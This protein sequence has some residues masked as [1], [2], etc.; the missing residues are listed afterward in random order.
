M[1][2]ADA[3]DGALPP[4]PQEGVP[5]LITKPLTTEEDKSFALKLVADSI[6]QQRNI[7]A[8]AIIFHPVIVA[9]YIGLMTIISQY[10][11]KDKGNIGVV[12]TTGAGVTMACLVAIRSATAGYLVVAEEMTWKWSQN[13]DGEADIIIGSRFGK[14]K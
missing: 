12:I 9:L 10:L 7:A 3:E 13:E 6:A 14:T 2:S 11:Y 8:R 4:N 5:E 1:S